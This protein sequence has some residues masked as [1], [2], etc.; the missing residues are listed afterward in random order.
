MLDLGKCKPCC[1]CSFASAAAAN[2]VPAVASDCRAAAS[3]AA[4]AARHSCCVCVSF[5]FFHT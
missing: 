3:A 1:N 4:A 5:F 2:L